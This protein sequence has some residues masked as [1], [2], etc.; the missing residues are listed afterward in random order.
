MQPKALRAVIAL[1]SLASALVPF[2]QGSVADAVPAAR[3]TAKPWF[4]AL[5]STGE[6]SPELAAAPERAHTVAT[7]RL[8]RRLRLNATVTP[9]DD[10]LDIVRKPDILPKHQQM[11][12]DVLRHY[13][14]W[15][16]ARLTNFYVRYDNPEHRGLAGPST[17]ILDGNVPDREFFALAVHESLHFFE[18][19]CLDETVAGGFSGFL[20]GD[21]RIDANDPSAQFYAISWI[22][23]AARREDSIDADFVSGYAVADPFEDLAE[24]GTAFVLQNQGLR[25]LAR[26]N[27]VIAA[28]IR[29]MERH[30]PEGLSTLATG[31][32]VYDEEERPWDTTRLAYKRKDR[33]TVAMGN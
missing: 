2:V 33:D 32:Y 16:L 15:C 8:R 27:N 19:G 18:L 21:T 4:G 28:K 3:E 10:I 24:F 26:R 23:S 22:D 29:W 7:A 31:L 9:S 20:D 25:R 13:P 5:G 12:S 17:I 1:A 14:D 6:I 30:L 11:A